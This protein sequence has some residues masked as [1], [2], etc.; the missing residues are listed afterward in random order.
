MAQGLVKW[1]NDSKGYGFIEPEGG[2]E[3]IFVHF[4]AIQMNG[5][6]TL[7][8]GSRV[9]YELA[10]GPKGKQALNITAEEAARSARRSP[11]GMLPV[12]Q[13]SRDSAELHAHAASAEHGEFAT[14]ATNASQNT[15]H[16][17]ASA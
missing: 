7:A 4:S 13:A 9:S 12:H 15:T 3:D 17:N 8:Q 11:Y 14:N 16:A 6:K 2:G 1:F 5:F 10:D